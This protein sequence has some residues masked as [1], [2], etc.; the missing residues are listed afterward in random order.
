MLSSDEGKGPPVLLLN[1]PARIEYS[2]HNIL[3]NRDVFSAKGE[4]T[5]QTR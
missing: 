5:F 2:A 4:R 3:P 1:S